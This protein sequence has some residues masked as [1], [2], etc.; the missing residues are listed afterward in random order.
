MEVHKQLPVPV[1]QLR[2]LHSVLTENGSETKRQGWVFVFLSFF[3]FLNRAET[4]MTN[5]N[6]IH[7]GGLVA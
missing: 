4:K 1:A 2:C 3:A 5:T 7:L 6:K